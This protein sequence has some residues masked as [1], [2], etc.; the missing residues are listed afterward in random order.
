ME[1]PLRLLWKLVKVVLALALVIPL[2]IIVLATALGVLGGLIG[3]AFLVAKLA[4]V[5]LL[6]W[7]AIR[8]VCHLMGG[9]TRG[10]KPIE[11]KQLPPSDPYYDAA[12]RELDREL[13]NAA[14]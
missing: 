13:G 9:P 3:L 7:G 11:V 6:A 8:L 5:G 1:G 12:M 4:V 10:A 2:S 14:R